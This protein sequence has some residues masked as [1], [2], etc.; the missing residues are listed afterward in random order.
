MQGL[1]DFK[2]TYLSMGHTEKEF[3]V[4]TDDLTKLIDDDSAVVGFY[5]SIQFIALIFLLA[6]C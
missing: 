3:R 4:S 6:V 2:D 5:Q 1:I